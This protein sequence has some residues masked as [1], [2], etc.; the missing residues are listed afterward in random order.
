MSSGCSAMA[1]ADFMVR[2]YGAEGWPTDRKK[3]RVSAGPLAD[4]RVP[5]ARK[6]LAGGEAQ[7]NHRNNRSEELCAPAGRE[8]RETAPARLGTA[9]LHKWQT[10]QPG[11]DP[12]GA[13]RRVAE[14]Q[15]TRRGGEWCRRV[16]PP[17]APRRGAR[18]G[19]GGGSGGFAAL[20]HRLI[21]YVPLARRG[22]EDT[23]IDSERLLLLTSRAAYAART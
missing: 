18:W 16:F 14:R 3:R 7:R 19:R 1:M 13:R 5:E 10:D 8:R 15:R 2:S 23:A 12:A 20:H 21:S 17:L 11:C 22:G 6:K 4:G 9:T